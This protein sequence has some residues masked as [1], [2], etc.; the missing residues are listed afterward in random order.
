MN[1]RVASIDI[2]RGLSILWIIAYHLWGDQKHRFA[3]SEPLYIAFRDHLLDGHWYAAAGALL[4]LVVGSGYQGVIVFMMLSG[5]SL[6]MNAYRRGE[7]PILRGYGSRF[8]KL[9]VAYWAGVVLIIG[10]IAVIALLQLVIDG[11]TFTKQWDQVTVQGSPVKLRAT[12]AL[13]AM[14]V[15]GDFVREPRAFEP[16]QHALWFIPLL[17]QYYLLF[18]F[19]FRLLQRIGPIRFLVVGLA[20]ALLARAA[21]NQ[22][23]YSQF[24]FIQLT[25]WEARYGVLRASEFIIGMAFGYVLVHRQ[26]EVQEWTGAPLD[27]AGI[28]VLAVLLQL[29]GSVMPGRSQIFDTLSFPILSVG[30]AL[31]M[32]PLLFKPGRLEQSWPAKA[33]CLL[34]VVAFPALITNE[35]MR[36][37]NSFLQYERLP[38]AIWWFF[39]VVIYVPVGT[40]LAY[41]L[42]SMLGL[43][44]GQRATSASAGATPGDGLELQPAGAG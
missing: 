30:L 23:A 22:I 4:E 28:L 8:R 13:Q 42:A 43:L 24:D 18:P 29:A 37:V 3:G 33:L 7:P 39:I 14:T 26:E 19:A 5:A 32:A 44:P 41:P 27:V 34:G 31:L 20:F 40:L 16:S 38:D 36:F 1:R 9:L 2:L 15:F 17:L 12:G 35:C 6:T 11:G 25:R 10:T 21:A